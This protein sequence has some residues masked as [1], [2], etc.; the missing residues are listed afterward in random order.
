M[1]SEKV[2]IDRNSKIIN[3]ME[4]N[5]LL[6]DREF[7]LFMLFYENPE[8][9]FTK[10]EL[11]EMVWN[12][13]TEISAVTSLVGRLRKKINAVTLAVGSIESGYGEGYYLLPPK[14]EPPV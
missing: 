3:T 9:V 13:N 5:I 11:L 4:K 6:S 2:V 12:G 7:Q 8:R 1:P 10:D 14:T